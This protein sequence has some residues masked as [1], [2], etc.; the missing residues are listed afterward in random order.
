MSCYFGVV[1][2]KIPLKKIFETSIQKIRDEN[3]GRNLTSRLDKHKRALFTSINRF[4][5]FMNN[6]RKKN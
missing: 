2:I 4:H 1:E 5:F 6:N 3:F